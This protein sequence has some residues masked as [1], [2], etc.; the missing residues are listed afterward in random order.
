MCEDLVTIS[1][2]DTEECVGESF[3]HNAFYL[4]AFFFSH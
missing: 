4:N 2:L 1:E 3:Q